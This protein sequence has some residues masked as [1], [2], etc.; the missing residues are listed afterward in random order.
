MVSPHNST[1]WWFG[2]LF[3]FPNTWDDDPIWLSYFSEVGIPPTSQEMVENMVS[4][5]GMRC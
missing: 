3:I 4:N 2:T 5:L 1:G